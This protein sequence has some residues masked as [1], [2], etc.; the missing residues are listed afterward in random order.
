MGFLLL[1]D[2]SSA[3][4]DTAALTN[5]LELIPE[6]NSFWQESLLWDKDIVLRAG[7][8]YKNNVLLSPNSPQGSPFFTSGLD[9]TIFRIP[10]DGWEVNLTVVGDDIRYFHSPGGINGE[11]LFLGSAQVQKYFGGVWRSGLEVRYSYSDQVLQEFLITGG[12]QAVEAQGNTLGAR[13]FIRRDLSTLWWVQLEAPLAREWWQAPLDATWKWGGQTD[14]GLTYRPH[15]QIVLSGGIF[16][17]PHDDWLARDALGNELPGRKLQIWRQT[18]ELKWE[19]QW[20]ASNHWSSIT[21]LGFNHNHDNGGGYYNNDRFY[22]SGELRFH[23]TDWELKGSS[24]LSYYDFPVQKIDGPESATL[25]LTSLNVNLRVERRL[26]KS[27]RGFLAFDYDQS[28]SNDPTAE[29]RARVF[30]GGMSWEF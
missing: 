27:I 12:A 25:H 24:A 3:L 13:P 20:D 7:F 21:K 30:S 23:T 22:V 5:G 26:Y 10:L 16:Y 14:V 4:A 8:G 18:A 28:A 29:Y 15:S 19:H 9:V 2:A 6:N 1:F 11:D 17:V